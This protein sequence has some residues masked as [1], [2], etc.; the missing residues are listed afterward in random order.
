V[1]CGAS[2]CDATS[3][4]CCIDAMNTTVRT[5]VAGTTCPPGNFRRECDDR[6]DCGGTVCCGQDN[7]WG[8]TCPPG[9][10]SCG[11]FDAAFRLDAIVRSWRGMY[12]NRSNKHSGHGM[13]ARL[14][15]CF[16]ESEARPCRISDCLACCNKALPDSLRVASCASKKVE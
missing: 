16:G 14:R 5:C 10:T 8:A 13:L 12:S 1:T 7:P 2:S 9:G 6:G 15:A 11:V 4:V 3:E